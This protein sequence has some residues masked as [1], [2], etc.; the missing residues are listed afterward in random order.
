VNASSVYGCNYWR[1]KQILHVSLQNPPPE[2]RPD[3]NEIYINIDSFMG[4]GTYT[5]YPGGNI[6]VGIMGAASNGGDTEGS[7]PGDDSPYENCTIKVTSTNLHTIPILEGGPTQG[8]VD[9]EVT[10]PKVG[11][12]GVGQCEC[13]VSPSTWRIRVVQCEATN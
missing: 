8:F 13:Q 12:T 11:A 10:C 1:S 6:L 2:T 9:L 4:P 5:T 7:L 3:Y